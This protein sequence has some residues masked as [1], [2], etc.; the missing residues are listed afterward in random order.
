MAVTISAFSMLSCIAVFFILPVLGT[1]TEC[2]IYFGSNMQ[3]KY[4]TKSLDVLRQRW[5]Q[6]QSQRI[7]FL[8]LGGQYSAS[9]RAPMN[10]LPQGASMDSCSIGIDL[11]ADGADATPVESTW[12]DLNREMEVLINRCVGG[13]GVGGITRWGGFVFT[14]VNPATVSTAHTCLAHPGLEDGMNLGMCMI[15]RAEAAKEAAKK[16]FAYSPASLGP[17]G[18]A[19]SSRFS[20][21]AGLRAPR[22]FVY[23]DAWFEGNDRTRTSPTGYWFG[24]S[25]GVPNPPLESQGYLKYAWVYN[26]NLWDR[27]LDDPIGPFG[28]FVNA[29]GGSSTTP[30]DDKLQKLLWQ[31]GEWVP[32]DSIVEGWESGRAWVNV[33]GRWEIVGRKLLTAYPWV[34]DEGI[35]WRHARS[36]VFGKIT[37]KRISSIL[38]LQNPAVTPSSL[39][40]STSN[41]NSMLPMTITISDE[42]ATLAPQQDE[43]NTS[44]TSLRAVT[45]MSFIL[46]TSAPEIASTS[47][48]TGVPTQ[49]IATTASEPT[50]EVEED[51]AQALLALQ[52][53]VSSTS[54]STTRKRERPA[55]ASSWPSKK[56]KTIP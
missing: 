56:A 45:A 10:G 41:L 7:P 39:T 24:L 40:T 54:K 14:V 3:M 8:R 34:L 55:T 16:L 32:P 29:P 31:R 13:S 48:A 50:I 36:W 19:R 49:S 28:A 22:G 51:A 42:T 12:A 44:P 6:G 21:P 2:M 11:A 9:S 17:A 35:W 38:F 23:G 20:A 47:S 37:S 46:T 1:Q 25:H 43:G 33:G 5:S 53:Q 4:C 52:G 30:G 15:K 26:G 27:A 18:G